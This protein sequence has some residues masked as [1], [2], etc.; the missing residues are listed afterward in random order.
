MSDGN[1][2]R[3]D[4]CGWKLYKRLKPGVDAYAYARKFEAFTAAIPE[5]IRR[6]TEALAEAVSLEYRAPSHT[7]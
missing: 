3:N 7:D 2:L 4:G 5:P 1:I 6:Y